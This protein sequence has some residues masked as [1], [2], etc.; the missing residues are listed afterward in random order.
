[1]PGVS[2]SQP[3]QALLARLDKFRDES[4][5]EMAPETTLEVDPLVSGAAKFYEKVRYLIDYREE[6]TIRRSAIER[7]LKRRVLIESQPIFGEELLRELAEGQYI[8]KELVT[9]ELGKHVSDV[10]S[11]YLS[12]SSHSDNPKQSD[13]RLLSFAATEIDYLFS[14]E[15]H[16]IDE[17]TA[18]AL[19]ASLRPHVVISGVS[20]QEIDL[21]LFC[22]V[23]RSL[24]AADNETLSYA[25]WLSYVPSWSTQNIDASKLVKDLDSILFSIEQSVK[26]SL[27]WQLNGKIKNESIYF[28]ILRELLLKKK[29]AAEWVLNNPKDLDEFTK[30]F[31][32]EKYEQENTRIKTS[33]IRAV[34][35][36]FVTKI[37]AAFVL[38]LPYELLVLGR[39]HYIP[40]LTNTLF[41]PT[42]LFLATRGVGYLDSANT[43]A[44]IAGMHEMFYNDKHRGIRIQANYTVL[45][46]IFG[47]TYLALVVALFLGMIGILT[48]LKFNFASIVLFLFFLALVSY[49]AF[50]IRY[51]AQRWRV[52]GKEGAISIVVHVLAVPV[53][54]AGRW[55]SRTFSSINVFVLFMDF[56]IETP[57]KLLLNFWSKFFAYLREK[58]DDMY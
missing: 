23:Q 13:R 24:L 28:K 22:A 32:K 47:F 15:A 18:E 26:N 40:L 14:P 51:H 33:G 57:F 49:F 41:H 36:L 5:K 21:Q 10:V 19:Y 25:L 30:D 27:Q 45:S 38:E 50:R 37:T 55:L 12:L 46:A 4:L 11:R 29:G 16:V 35:Y 31:L 20:E 8:P 3:I 6:H 44:V 53:V 54:R 17:A 58:A 56:I 48:A 43:D 9:A 39:V 2:L 1:M 42:L 7:I 34:A 52:S